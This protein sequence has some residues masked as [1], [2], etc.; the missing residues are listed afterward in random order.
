M[1]T[2][3]ALGWNGSA[4]IS[5]TVAGAPSSVTTAML[6]TNSVD[7]SKL[8][9][10]SVGTSAISSSVSIETSGVVAAG[11]LASRSVKVLAPAPSVEF[12]ELKAPT[13]TT[14][15]SYSLSLPATSGSSNQLLSATGSGALAWTDRTHYFIVEDLE[16][17]GASGIGCTQ[18]SWVTRILNTVSYSSVSGASLSSNQV[19]LPPGRYLVEG[20]ATANSVNLH[21]AVLYNLTTASIVIPGTLARSASGSGITSDSHITGV[22]NIVA[23]TV[24]EIRHRCEATNATGF[25]RASP[26]WGVG[27]KAVVIKFEK[28]D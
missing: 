12:V 20:A 21:Q 4:W 7:S 24:F 2:G 10:G 17:D 9:A 15:A 23:P 25:S 14:G 8:A 6:Q 3:Q 13:L 16:P 1:S 26:G 27:S 5:Q 28:I 18:G 11:A 22:I 19:T